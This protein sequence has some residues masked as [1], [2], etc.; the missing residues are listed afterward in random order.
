[1]DETI[2]T[3]GRDDEAA[4]MDELRSEAKGTTA[5]RNGASLTLLICMTIVP[6]RKSGNGGSREATTRR[7]TE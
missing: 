3:L 4:G 2:R 7:R 1:M 5:G 6:S